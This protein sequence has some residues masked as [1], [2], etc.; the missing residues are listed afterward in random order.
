[1]PQL[2]FS[3]EASTGSNNCRATE[4]IMFDS[5][6]P[7]YNII[8]PGSSTSINGTIRTISGTSVDGTE[9]SFNDEGFE[10]VGINVLNTLNSPRIVCSKVN[11]DQFLSNLPRSK[12]FTTGITLNSSDSNLS[13]QINLDTAFT[14]FRSSRFNKPI[15]DYASDGRVKSIFNDPHSAVLF[16]ILYS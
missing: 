14:E 4:N 7:T 16:Q 3:S 8:T 6:I 10:P 1:M 15:T 11:E 13:P 5:I 2:N 12:S 9:A